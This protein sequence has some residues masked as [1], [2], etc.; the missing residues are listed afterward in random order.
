MRRW[1]GR[2]TSDKWPLIRSENRK[3]RDRKDVRGDASW[4]RALPSDVDRKPWFSAPLRSE[5]RQAPRDAGVTKNEGGLA[6]QNG[7]PPDRVR[8]SRAGRRASRAAAGRGREARAIEAPAAAWPGRRSYPQRQPQGEGLGRERPHQVANIIDLA[9]F[10]TTNSANSP[11]QPKPFLL[12]THLEKPDAL[13][14][15][16]VAG[17]CLSTLGV[18]R[19]LHAVCHNPAVS[20]FGR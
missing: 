2:D 20:L 5:A 18:S 17:G 11:S 15:I 4:P 12:S 10:S 7:T 8:E 16:G 1:A 19:N 9:P 14:S 3:A 6:Y 13:H